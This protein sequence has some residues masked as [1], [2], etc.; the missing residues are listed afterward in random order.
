MH[1]SGGSNRLCGGG[2]GLRSGEHQHRPGAGDL[3]KGGGSIQ[4][5]AFLIGTNGEKRP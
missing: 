4:R 2:V 3:E 1:I 5:S